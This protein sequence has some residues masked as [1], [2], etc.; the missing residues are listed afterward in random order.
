M[1][2]AAYEIEKLVTRMAQALVDRPE[3]V[4]VN[5]IEGNSSIV[6]ELNVAKED[7]GKV[8][9]KQGRMAG[10]MRIII[11]AVSAKTK[12]RTTLEIIE[13]IPTKLDFETKNRKKVSR[14]TFLTERSPH[15]T[16]IDS[17]R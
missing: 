11:A 1:N 17:R 16:S 8:I 5:A 9:G 14:S 13:E 2:G 3:H 7:I 4:L 15:G 10:A 12:H 6:L